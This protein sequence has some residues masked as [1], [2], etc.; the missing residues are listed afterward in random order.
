MG[1]HFT[2]QVNYNNKVESFEGELRQLGYTHK[3]YIVVNGADVVFEP[4]EERNYR[5]II[6]HPEMADKLDKSLLQAI[7]NE[8]EQALK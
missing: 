2:L 3:I 7:V 1:E 6:D 4:D 8:L 5:V